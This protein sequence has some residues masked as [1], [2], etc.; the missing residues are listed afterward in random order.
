MNQK[1][2]AKSCSNIAFIKYWGNHDP[3]LRLP[4]NDSLSM[5][6]EALTTTTT[7]EF[8]PSLDSDQVSLNDA[9]ADDGTTRR[10]GLHLDLMRKQANVQDHARVA[11]ENNFP[12]ASGIASSASAF[13]ALTVA[14]ASALTLDLNERELSILAR[15]GSGSAARSIPAGFVEWLASRDSRQSFARSIAAPDYWDLRDVIAVVSKEAKAV[16]SSEGHARSMTSPFMGA[17]QDHLPA[18]FHHMRR[19]IRERDLA[20]LGTDLEVEA[21]ELHAIAMTS[22]PPILYWTAGTVRVIQ[23]VIAWRKEGLAAYFTIDAGPNVH[24]ICTAESANE[25]ATRVRALPE[26]QDVLISGP[27]DGARLSDAHLF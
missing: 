25:L 12:A 1:A 2:T 13:A 5:N 24:L 19:S 7:V 10:V 20:A 22:R 6:L 11:S 14:A 3:R 8:D 9:A 27:G 23:S 15:Q 4:L 17:R 16:S 26:I 18:R 21:L